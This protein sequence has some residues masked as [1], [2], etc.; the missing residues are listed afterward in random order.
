[1]KI[2]NAT[3]SPGQTF[4]GIVNGELFTV[5]AVREEPTVDRLRTVTAVYF[6]QHRNDKKVRV[7]LATAQRLLLKEVPTP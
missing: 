3:F 4:Q 7:E 6:R 1:M 5:E 2:I